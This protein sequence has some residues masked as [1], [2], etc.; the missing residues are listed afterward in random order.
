MWQHQYT[1]V[2]MHMDTLREEADRNRRWRTQDEANGRPVSPRGSG[3]VRAAAARWL[4]AASRT[5]ARL[6]RRLDEGVSLD[7]AGERLG[8]GA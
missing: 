8:G 4:A 3:R 5:G 2:A 6:A 1:L 7:L